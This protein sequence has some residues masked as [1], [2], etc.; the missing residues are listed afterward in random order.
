MK[1]LATEAA[2]VFA[3]CLVCVALVLVLSEIL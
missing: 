2:L 3:T 1:R